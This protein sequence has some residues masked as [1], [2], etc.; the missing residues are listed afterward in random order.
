MVLHV[1]DLL[2]VSIVGY[3]SSSYTAVHTSIF[4]FL[5]LGGWGRPTNWAGDDPALFL[6]LEGDSKVRL[7]GGASIVAG[8]V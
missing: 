5:L 1:A 2:T 6:P 4:V 3:R 8:L 7:Y